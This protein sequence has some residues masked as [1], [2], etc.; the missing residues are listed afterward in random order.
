MTKSFAILILR[1]FVIIMSLA[2]LLT[3]TK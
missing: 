1:Q 2:Y 3:S